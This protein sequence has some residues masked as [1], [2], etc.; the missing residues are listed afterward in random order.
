MTAPGWSIVVPTHNRGGFVRRAIASVRAQTIDDWEL[1]V[2][3][4][5]SE[6]DTREIA[7]S[8]RDEPRVRYVCQPHAGRSV[9]RN[10]GV[11]LARG[12]I[13]CFLDSDDTYLETALASHRRAFAGAHGIGMTIGG[14]RNVDEGGNGLGERLPWKRHPEPTPESWLF[15]CMAL[16]G[17]VAIRREWLETVGGFD[18]S[19]EP[20]EDWD[21][22]LGLAFSGC[23]TGWTHDIVCNRLVH[24]GNSTNDVRA[25]RLG[26]M[27]ALDKAFR[28]PGLD[29]GVAALERRARAWAHLA[30]ARNAA[31][32][33]RDDLAAEELRAAAGLD[34]LP[35]W[36]RRGPAL[37]PLGFPALLEALLA[38]ERLRHGSTGPAELAARW[39]L[40][41]ADVRRGL[42][43]VELSRFFAAL[44]DDNGGE[45]GSRLHRGLALDHRW[46][47]H[48]AV[49][50]YLLRHPFRR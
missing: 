30:S 2:V 29:P 31:S 23:P 24:P 26:T 6:D 12:E 4:D 8:F 17:S 39:S 45:A 14:Y 25:H 38:D 34:A 33:G 3:D 21:L 18:S 44:A 49:T 16:P 40:S 36:E 42:A 10:H 35:A 32:L 19:T 41:V 1:I 47:A 15:D 9:A 20:A 46:L 50:S 11:G 48:H 22:F 7:T 13:V 5:G 28:R 27:R 37:S 43:R